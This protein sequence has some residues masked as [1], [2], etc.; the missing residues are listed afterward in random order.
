MS[1]DT[2]SNTGSQNSLYPNEFGNFLTEI[3]AKSR[4][5]QVNS[6]FFGTIS[7]CRGLIQKL[8]F[9]KGF[10]YLSIGLPALVQIRWQSRT[11]TLAGFWEKV[12]ICRGKAI[13]K[14]CL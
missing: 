11:A 3:L 8:P 7:V 2:K 9:S 13:P 14:K 5:I 1:K 6:E 12:L 10:L 4:K